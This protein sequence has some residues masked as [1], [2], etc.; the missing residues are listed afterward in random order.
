[1]ADAYFVSARRPY[2]GRMAKRQRSYDREDVPSTLT[3]CYGW[4][5]SDRSSFSRPR[6]S[7]PPGRN[8]MIVGSSGHIAAKTARDHASV[9]GA[10]CSVL[11]ARCSVLGA[12][13]SVLG[14]RVPGA[15][16]VGLVPCRRRATRPRSEKFLN[17]SLAIRSISI[18]RRTNDKD[19]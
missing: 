13:C 12:R 11:G 19:R 1:M 10:R 2:R 9:L 8:F 4:C 17:Q 15:P 7:G 18:Y 16:G 5:R 3:F 14:A 6:G